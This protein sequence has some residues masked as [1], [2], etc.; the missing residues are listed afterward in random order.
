MV[1]VRFRNRNYT[2][3][4]LW[5]H[6][7][8]PMCTDLWG[9]PSGC[10][11]DVTKDWFRSWMT[12]RWRFFRCHQQKS[13]HIVVMPGGHWTEIKH[14]RQVETGSQISLNWSW[15]L[16]WWYPIMLCGKPMKTAPLSSFTQLFLRNLD[17]AF[18]GISDRWQVED[19]N[20]EAMSLIKAIQANPDP[21]ATWPDTV[22][23]VDDCSWL[24][25]HVASLWPYGTWLQIWDMIGRCALRGMAVVLCQAVPRCRGQTFC[26]AETRR[27]SATWPGAAPF[28]RH[29]RT[30]AQSCPELPS[31]LPSWLTVAILHRSV[32]EV[33]YVWN[34][35]ATVCPPFLAFQDVAGQVGFGTMPTCPVHI[36]QRQDFGQSWKEQGIHEPAGV[37]IEAAG[38][39]CFMKFLDDLWSLRMFEDSSL[40]NWWKLMKTVHCFLGSQVLGRQLQWQS[41]GSCAMN[42]TVQHGDLMGDLLRIL[43]DI[44]GIYTYIHVYIYICI[45]VYI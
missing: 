38:I 19:M 27:C 45:C 42:F 24:L 29:Q 6:N 2:H 18:C 11:G 3:C 39:L 17:E 1:S 7:Y 44:C 25:H 43:W 28:E 20:T 23:T 41:L 13:L 21:D 26:S 12:R 4:N 9:L 10:K 5:W 34:G 16:G 35:L 30:A 40:E 8:H 31:W 14:F 22:M 32:T 33:T 36:C 15:Y 37:Q